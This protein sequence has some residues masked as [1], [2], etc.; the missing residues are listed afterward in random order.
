MLFLLA[1]YQT[2]CIPA[3]F[4]WNLVYFVDFPAADWVKFTDF[5]EF[6]HCRKHFRHFNAVFI[7]I[8]PLTCR[9]TFCASSG[10]TTWISSKLISVFVRSQ[11][12]RPWEAA[13]LRPPA[14]F[15]VKHN[16]DD[17]DTPNWISNFCLALC[18]SPS[19][20]LLRCHF[21]RRHCPFIFPLFLLINILMS[22][23]FVAAA[24]KC[25]LKV[26]QRGRKARRF[27]FITFK[28]N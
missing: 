3:L 15:S 19:G 1:C 5:S 21:D 14:H 11:L 2:N 9:S 20:D 18:F 16:T 13:G 12:R 4:N 7:H 23:C 28:S 6:E 26:T 22:R 17:S 10:G 8:I 27:C 24:L 25:H